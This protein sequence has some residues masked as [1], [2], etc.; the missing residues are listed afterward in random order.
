[1]W[2]PSPSPNTVLLG[3]RTVVAQGIVEVALDEPFPDR[4][5][6]CAHPD[7]PGIAGNPGFGEGDQFRAL[8][9][10]FLDISDGL[11]DRALQVDP[12]R[13]RLHDCRLVLRMSDA[14]GSSL[15]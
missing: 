1:M 15:L 12:D 3:E 6:W 7:I 8:F 10:G 2:L 5:G 14:H 4:P 13:R 9:R 11:G